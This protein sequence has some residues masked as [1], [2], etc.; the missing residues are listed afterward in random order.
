MRMS[1]ARKQACACVLMLLAVPGFAQTPDEPEEP[2][3]RFDDE[4]TVVE[5]KEPSLTLPGPET[6]AREI[7]E[8]PGGAALVDAEVYKRGR[9]STLKDALDFTPGVFVQ[10]RFGSEEA[11]LSIRGS[12]LQRTFH[13]RGIKL[14]Q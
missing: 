6:A 12:G 3:D 9:T 4:I 8:I 5:K 10:S 1:S 2:E 7:A 14:L 13:G 11:R